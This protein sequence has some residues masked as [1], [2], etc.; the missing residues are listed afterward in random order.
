MEAQTQTDMGDC[1]GD[2]SD[3]VY[4]FRGEGEYEKVREAVEDCLETPG[5]PLPSSFLELRIPEM[6][7]V[8]NKLRLPEVG[9]LI[10]RLPLDVAVSFCD[11]PALK[12]R[13]RICEQLAP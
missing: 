12:R 4:S 2:H 9:D 7:L 8:A 10:R 11:S 1:S 5:A 13:P 6:A 3:H